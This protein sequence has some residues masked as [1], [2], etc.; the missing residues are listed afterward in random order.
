MRIG[1]D[2]R[3][4]VGKATGVGRY[5]SGLLTEWAATG[6]ASR[7]EFLLY[8]HAPVASVPRFETRV[9]PGTSGTRWQQVTLP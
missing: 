4:I 3:E 5:L 6:A 2:A 7:H 8:T 1:I 9:L